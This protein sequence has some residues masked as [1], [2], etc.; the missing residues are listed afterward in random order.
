MTAQSDRTY[1]SV[2]MILHWV[3]ATLLIPMLFFLERI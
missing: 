1:D 3:I 2:A